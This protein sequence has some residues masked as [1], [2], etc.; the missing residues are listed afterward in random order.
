VPLQILYLQRPDRNKFEQ[1]DWI[2]VTVW[3]YIAGWL[4]CVLYLPGFVQP[5]VTHIML[6]TAAEWKI[7]CIDFT[8][9][10][11]SSKSRVQI[12]RNRL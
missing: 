10:A 6:G 11:S 7:F 9:A 5:R 4:A 12:E 2:S 8:F 1:K 3:Y